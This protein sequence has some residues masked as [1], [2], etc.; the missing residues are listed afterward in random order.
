VRGTNRRGRR[1]SR[2]F[3]GNV[4]H[5]RVPERPDDR[6]RSTPKA[7]ASDHRLHDPAADP[8]TAEN[9]RHVPAPWGLVA[10]STD[11]SQITRWGRAYLWGD[12]DAGHLLHHPDPKPP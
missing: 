2:W 5:E 4:P 11:D 8:A 1:G 3:V 9:R 12:L 10:S 6:G 7:T